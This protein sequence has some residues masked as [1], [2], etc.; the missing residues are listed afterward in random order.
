MKMNVP[1]L[2]EEGKG[3]GI[4]HQPQPQQNDGDSH[5]TN[6]NPGHGL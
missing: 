5:D 1:D 6:V 2:T 4:L 3:T